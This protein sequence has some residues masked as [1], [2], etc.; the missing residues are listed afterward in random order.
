MH[1]YFLKFFFKKKTEKF[2]LLLTD[3]VGAMLALVHAARVTALARPATSMLQLAG[4]AALYSCLASS[5]FVIAVL[6]AWLILSRLAPGSRPVGNFGKVRKGSLFFFSFFSCFLYFSSQ[7][8]ILLESI[9]SIPEAMI[10]ADATASGRMTL[11]F[12][13][14]IFSLNMA[15]TM[16]TALDFLATKPEKVLHR[17]LLTMIFFSVGSLSFSISSTV[18]SSFLD[19]LASGLYTWLN[20]IP[21]LG[22]VVVGALLIW[23]LMV[24]E[25]R[26]HARQLANLPSKDEDVA[27]EEG[28]RERKKKRKKISAE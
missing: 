24:I 15:N 25:E 20:L 1:E 17:L 7:F 6:I 8:M 12:A 26:I 11:A 23:V 9:D 3:G 4:E 28:N 21:M 22:G 5:G 2:F 19:H 18:F 16:A 13:F 27:I 14:S 10:I